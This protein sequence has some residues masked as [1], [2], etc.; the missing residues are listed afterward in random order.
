MLTLD[1]NDIEITLAQEAEIRFREP[2]IAIVNDAETTFGETALKRSRLDPRHTHNQFWQ[3][4]NA[5]PVTPPGRGVKNQ[6][7][8]VYQHLLALKEATGLRDDD[9]LIVVVPSSTTNEQLS[10]LLGIAQEAK[11]TV[12]GF[13][14]AAVA[15]ASNLRLPETCCVLDIGWDRA[16]ITELSV[17]ELVSWQA[18][19][20]SQ[21]IGL[22]SL[23]E[24]WIDVVADRFVNETRFDP[25]RIAD[26]E[27]QVF[28]QVLAAIQT[29]FAELVISIDHEGHTR[30][31]DIDS[32]ALAAKSRPRFEAVAAQIGQTTTIVATNRAQRIPGLLP[33]LTNG[34]HQILNLEIDAAITACNQHADVLRNASSV[35]YIRQLPSQGVQAAS[36]AP[37]PQSA[38]THLLCGST[39]IALD[40]GRAAG[41]HPACRGL[42][43]AFRIS[44]AESGYVLRP[45]DGA[46][47]AVNNEQTTGEII[48]RPGDVI[49]AGAVRFELIVVSN[50]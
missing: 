40:N 38:P 21:S 32:A 13:V 6:A 17:D 41:E 31:V 27:Q 8:L 25:L 2:G 14:D 29:E 5:D 34:G 20:E 36:P 49:R 16:S 18:I 46:D 33:F 7:D 1:I 47:I 23:I 30:R 42:E 11:L 39:A 4:L 15:G 22:A 19:T 24:G 50:G 9:E 37:A 10:L 35:Q 3:R 44:K 26:T 48:V 43:H 28:D 45:D 12:L